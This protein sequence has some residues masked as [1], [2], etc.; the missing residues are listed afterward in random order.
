[1]TPVELLATFLYALAQ[2]AALGFFLG[3]VAF[4]AGQVWRNR[5]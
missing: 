4:I 2:I 3:L 1:M 5:K